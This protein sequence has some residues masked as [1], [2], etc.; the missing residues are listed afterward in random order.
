LQQA[1]LFALLKAEFVDLLSTGLKLHR[2]IDC[3]PLVGSGQRVLK[4]VL[5]PLVAK[6][7]AIRSSPPAIPMTH[8]RLARACRSEFAGEVTQ[9][10]SERKREGNPSRCSAGDI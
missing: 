3:Q 7:G 5:L 10:R 4:N 8:L 9:R 2:R 1:F 6:S